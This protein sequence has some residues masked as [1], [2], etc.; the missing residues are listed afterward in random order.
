MKK[1]SLM[2]FVLL[3]GT[4]FSQPPNGSRSLVHTQSARTFDSGRLEVHSNMNFFTRAFR[5]Y[6]I[7]SGADKF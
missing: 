5:I 1:I 2:L 6:R 4:V 3:C 7:G